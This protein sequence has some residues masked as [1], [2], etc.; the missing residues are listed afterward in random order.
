MQM[1]P[2]SLD[3]I[4]YS[5]VH[6]APFE[7][8]VPAKEPLAAP[9]VLRVTFSHHVFSEKWNPSKHAP[10]HEFTVDGEK[11]AFCPLRY[12]CSHQIRQIVEYNI[13]GK[14]FESRDSNGVLRHLF[15]GEID[16]VQFP[17]FFNLRKA[18]RIPGIDGI[19]HI[20]SAYKK[21]DLPAKV[22]LQSVK[23]ARLVHINCPPSRN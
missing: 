17:V 15:Y 6:L 10:S 7:V 12:Q 20:I 11:R 23:F 16:G 4:E 19:L 22:R 21:P 5:F 2:F 9:A 13:A 3:G 8:T 1:K 18:D 14:A